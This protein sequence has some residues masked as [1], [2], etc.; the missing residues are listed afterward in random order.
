MLVLSIVV[1]FLLAGTMVLLMPALGLVM[2]YRRYRGVHSLEC[3]ETQAAVQIVL[4][5]RDAAIRSLHRPRLRVAEC[6]RWPERRGCGQEC[7]R[8][9]ALARDREPDRVCGHPL[10]GLRLLD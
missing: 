2:T 3:P 7:T 1:L 5:A 4:Q 8:Q 10:F 6:S 9:A